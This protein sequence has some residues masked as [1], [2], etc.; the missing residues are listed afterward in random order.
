MLMMM[1]SM[2]MQRMMRYWMRLTRTRRRTRWKKKTDL[3][4]G[5]GYVIRCYPRASGLVAEIR[6][7]LRSQSISCLAAVMLMK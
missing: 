3:G 5:R 4:V 2:W 6:S 1:T 7:R